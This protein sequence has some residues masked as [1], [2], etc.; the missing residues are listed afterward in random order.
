MLGSGARNAEKLGPCGLREAT[1][2]SE[3]TQEKI[4]N[5]C[6]APAEPIQHQ[7]Q[8]LPIREVARRTELLRHFSSRPSDA[9]RKPLM[10]PQR[11]TL[12]IV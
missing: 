4:G 2:A 7:R 1:E 6:S 9:C 12:E 11:A 5:V 8:E 3:M 10:G